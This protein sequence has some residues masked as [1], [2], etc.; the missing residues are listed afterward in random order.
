MNKVTK[1]IAIAVIAGSAVFS[2]SA[3]STPAPVETITPMPAPTSVDLASFKSGDT[4][5][6]KVGSAVILQVANGTEADWE[7]T[8]SDDKVAVFVQ[9]IF[10]DNVVAI[11]SINP[12]AEGKATIKLTD[13]K[14]GESKTIQLEVTK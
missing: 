5:K 14:T 1:T 6:A 13:A 8:T 3:C 2:L 12:I 11:P 7:G 4:V 10:T 9:G